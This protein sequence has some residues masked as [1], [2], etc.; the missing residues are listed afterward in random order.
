LST[1]WSTWQESAN[2][3]AEVVVEVGVEVV[4]D[5]VVEVVV[6]VVDVVV[7]VVPVVVDVDVVPVVV[8]V[9]VVGAGPHRRWRATPAGG[10]QN[11][12]QQLMFSRQTSPSLRQTTAS[13]WRN[14]IRPRAP[15]TSPPRSRR[16]EPD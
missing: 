16:R 8:E 11:L 6:D 2:G 9:V 1:Q 5:V 3:G 14:P 10:L 15:A 7:E 12:E 4:V 13:A